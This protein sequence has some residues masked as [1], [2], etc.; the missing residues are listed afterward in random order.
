MAV[1]IG[2]RPPERAARA[3]P[4][5]AD[6]RRNRAQLLAAAGEELQRGQQ[7]TLA[8]VAQRARLS[9]ATAYRHFSSAEEVVEAY[10]GG[11]WDDVDARSRKIAKDDFPAFCRTWI[12]AVLDWGP[13]LVYLRS[14]D[15]F[16]TRRS[17]GDLRVGR[18]LAV[19]EPRIE[20]ELRAAGTSCSPE[21][22]YVLAVWNALADPREILDQRQ[23]LGWS[24]ARLSDNLCRTVRAAIRR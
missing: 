11:F 7:F 17:A 1:V 19:A 24:S 10:V 16:L 22:S 15:G 5:R 6:S 21:L 9:T 18:L 8:E 2:P 20:A 23:A 4:G 12:D 13:A 14:R 3:G